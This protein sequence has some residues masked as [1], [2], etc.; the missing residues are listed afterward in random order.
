MNHM[1]IARSRAVGLLEGLVRQP[2]NPMAKDRLLT[3]HAT[4]ENVVDGHALHGPA[5]VRS[6][7]RDRFRGS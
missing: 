7:A 5:T 2:P 4:D 3:E 1:D 6:P